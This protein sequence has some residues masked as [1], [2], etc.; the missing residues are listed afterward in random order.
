MKELGIIIP[1]YNAHNT[2]RK[3]L[4]S[5]GCFS[6]LDKVEVI[7]VDDASEEPYDY[8]L[9]DFKDLD[10]N[11][12]RLEKNVGPGA[13]RNKGIDFIIEKKIPYIMF[14]DADDYFFDSFFWT[15]ISPEA[16]ENN[17]FFIFSFFEQMSNTTK[18]DYDIWLFGK[19][20]KTSI[21]KENNIRFENK[22]RRNE[23]VIFNFLYTAFVELSYKID[24][25][26][27]FW[28]DTEGSLTKEEKYEYLA[29]KEFC[30]ILAE[31]YTLIKNNLT[32][33]RKEKLIYNRLIRIYNE[34]NTLICLYPDLFSNNN[35]HKDFFKS[36]NKLYNSFTEEGTINVEV[37]KI[38]QE[39]NLLNENN[40]FSFAWIGFPEFIHR[41]K[42][43]P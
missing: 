40:N 38:F 29:L 28:C 2:I 37:D 31:K 22:N 27:Y 23:D 7:I 17:D 21:I 39:Y 5:I 42:E 10:L 19:I 33:K 24:E 32:Q 1:A 13:A 16:K 3:L 20:Y 36:L 26:I 18:E 6:F 14:A 12:I 35:K 30:E 11:L 9:D 34:I 43:T 25:P 15:A 41:I 8:L 4:H